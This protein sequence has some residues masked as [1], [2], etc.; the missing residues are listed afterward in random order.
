[1]LHDTIIIVAVSD[2]KGEGIIII[3]GIDYFEHVYHIYTDDD[4]AFLAFEDFKIGG[5]E[6]EMDENGVRFIHIYDT[7]TIWL[8]D[9][10]SF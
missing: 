10:I 8:E 9:D 7:N 6:E 5:G 3:D 2:I 4:F 1:M